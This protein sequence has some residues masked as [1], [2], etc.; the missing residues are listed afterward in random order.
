MTIFVN[1]KKLSPRYRLVFSNSTHVFHSCLKYDDIFIVCVADRCM[2]LEILRQPDCV[3]T[4]VAERSKAN[5][6]GMFNDSLQ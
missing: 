6:F 1:I 4:D 5:F 3:V 2:R